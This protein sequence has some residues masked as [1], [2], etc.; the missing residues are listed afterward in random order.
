M[1]ARLKGEHIMIIIIDVMMIL[2][3]SYILLAAARP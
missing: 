1:R 2:R 3:A